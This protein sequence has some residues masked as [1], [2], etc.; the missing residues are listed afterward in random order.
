M[1]SELFA[2]QGASAATLAGRLE[3]PDGPIEAFAVFAHC[4]A[5]TKQSIAAVRISRALAS[6]GIGVLRFDFTG[7][8]ED[9]ADYADA[10][11]GNVADVIAAAEAM[12]LAK[13]P[14]ALL[15]GHSLGG[16]AVLAAACQLPE[17]A[18]VATIAAPFG[19]EHVKSL[20]GDR[21]AQIRRDGAAEVNLGGRRLHVSRAFLDDLAAHEQGS[22]ISQL[23]RPLLILH[24]PRDG[25]VGIENASAIFEYAQHPKS[26][27]ALGSADHLLTDARDAEYV[28]RLI[29]CWSR[30]YLGWRGGS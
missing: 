17:I 14:P 11:S 27:I 13:R 8:G 24:S 22:R 15:I 23:D 4:F 19:V 1:P 3:L 26:F 28:A 16:A 30:P 29:A 18:A 2:F 21:L 9:G 20:F 6:H 12:E 7:L 10:F 5:C 25:V